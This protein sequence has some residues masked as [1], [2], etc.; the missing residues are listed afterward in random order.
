M[1]FKSTNPGKVG[2][3]VS[4]SAKET[5]EHESHEQSLRLTQR[6]QARHYVNLVIKSLLEAVHHMVPFVAAGGILIAIAFLIDGTSVD[7]SALPPEERAAF[8]SITPLAAG[9]SDVGSAAF[10]FMLPIFAAF[11]ARGLGGPEAFMAGFAGGYLASQGSSG[12]LGAILA[13][14]IAGV[15]CNLMRGFIAETSRQIQRIAPVLLYPLF[16]LLVMYLLLRFAVGP[17]AIAFEACLTSIL[18]NL[19]QGNRTV[20]GGVLG[21]MMATDLGGPI[22]KTA[23]HFGTASILIGEPDIM[24]AVM[25]GGMVPPC[26]IALSMLLFRNRFTQDERDTCASTLFMGLAF[27]T[28]GAIPFAITDLFRVIPSCMVGSAVASALSEAFG[29]TLMAPHGGIFVFPV[30]GNAALYLLSLF[31]GSIV[32]ALVLGVLKRPLP[33]QPEEPIAAGNDG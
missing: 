25:L 19:A 16:S 30:V 5:K 18:N 15:V 2:V 27:I 21:A 11:F 17:I 23:Y 26:G 20:L 13:A 7:L 10:N 6:P 33:E 3:I 12:F 32:C 22:N 24:A 31:L 28:E 9:L 1:A 14:V 29:C 8:G 4:R